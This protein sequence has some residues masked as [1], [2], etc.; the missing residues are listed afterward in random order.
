MSDQSFAV[1]GL[2]GISSDRVSQLKRANPSVNATNVIGY[3]NIWP[4]ADG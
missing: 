4:A 1:Y 2:E 3:M